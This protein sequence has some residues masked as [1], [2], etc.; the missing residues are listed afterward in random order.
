MIISLS[1]EYFWLQEDEHN[2][3]TFLNAPQHDFDSNKSSDWIHHK[4]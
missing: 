4:N 1:V 2:I 3:W